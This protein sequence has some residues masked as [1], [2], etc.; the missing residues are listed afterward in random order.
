[1]L[2]TVGPL[3]TKICC[4]LKHET[5]YDLITGRPSMDVGQ[6]SLHFVKDVVTVWNGK[7]V[8]HITSK[9][10]GMDVIASLSDESTSYKESN[11]GREQTD[12]ERDDGESRSPEGLVLTLGR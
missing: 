4:L 10:E 12:E 7:E 3:V 5:P 11:K 8:A 1:M 2:V 9:T 6:E